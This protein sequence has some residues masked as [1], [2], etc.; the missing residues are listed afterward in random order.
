MSGSSENTP[1]FDFTNACDGMDFLSQLLM[2]NKEL[3]K[4]SNC[5]GNSTPPEPEE[6][7]E[8]SE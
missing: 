4:G 5:S 2:E 1:T 6:F 3:G 8:S 7:M